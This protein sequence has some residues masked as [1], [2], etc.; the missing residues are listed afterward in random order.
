MSNAPTGFEVD[1]EFTA[2]VWT[3]VTSLARSGPGVSIR[4]GRTSPTGAPQVGS[5][6]FTLDNASGNFTPLNGGSTYYPNVVPGKRVRVSYGSGASLRA[7]GYVKSWTPSL[8]GGVA[9]LVTVSAIDRLGALGSKVLR[10]A[11]QEAI[12]STNP[13][14]YIPLDDP[15][16]STAVS[17]WDGSNSYGWTLRGYGTATFKLGDPS[18]GL[19]DEGTYAALTN[20]S[21]TGGYAVSVPAVTGSTW[22][23]LVAGT[24]TGPGTGDI[25]CQADGTLFNTHIFASMPN[26]GGATFIRTGDG[27]TTEIGDETT[28]RV[29]DGKYHAYVI[30]AAPGAVSFYVDGNLVGTAAITA[31]A[32]GQAF[33]GANDRGSTPWV[34]RIG[35]FATWQGT[36]LTAGQV[37]AISGAITSGWSGDL[38]GARIARYLGFAGL[39]S[40]DWTL[41]TGVEPVSGHPIAGKS[42]VDACN[43]VVDTESG[44]AAFFA[45]VDGKVRFIDRTYRTTGTPVMTLDSTLDISPGSWQPFYDDLAVLN[46]STVTDNLGNTSEYTNAASIAAIG[47]A[48]DSV[49]EYAVAP[50]AALR[51]AQYRVN[52]SQ[53]NVRF[54]QLT[55]NIATVSNSATLYAAL[56]NITIGSRIRITNIPKSRNNASGAATRIFHVDTLDLYVEGWSETI[57]DDQYI[58]TFDLSPADSPARGQ[59]DGGDYG[60]WQPDAGALTLNAGINSSVTSLA[61]KSTGTP[62]ISTSAGDFPCY[63]QID[64]EVIKLNS[65]PA[66][67]VSPQTFT[68]TRAQQGTFADAH[69]AGAV[70]TGWPGTNWTL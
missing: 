33:L 53:S 19:W 49:T 12:L 17:A 40:S 46:D 66:G 27:A 70:V 25:W 31:A 2:G 14:T 63:V 1:I 21:G 59:W 28:P 35:H 62:T 16:G 58:V 5:L 48:S 26:G 56:P 54:P 3:N 4:V 11:P 47:Y 61:L 60:R 43:A 39:T 65:A 8:D 23:V 50:D 64:Q 29:A 38:P 41:D 68:V 67:A 34:G 52:S 7:V 20:V 18:A 36:A 6:S 15:Q 51:I 30:S 69:T 44:G 32:N 57:A 37:A 13:T 55:I 9:P 45:N 10:T 24:F 42:V 22:S